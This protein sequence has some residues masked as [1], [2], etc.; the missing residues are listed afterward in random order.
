MVSAGKYR[1]EGQEM[2]YKAEWDVL[3]GEDCL[4]SE[5]GDEKDESHCGGS[6]VGVLV[7]SVKSVGGLKERMVSTIVMKQT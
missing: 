7:G 6:V 2:T 4:D 5:S 1:I 3:L